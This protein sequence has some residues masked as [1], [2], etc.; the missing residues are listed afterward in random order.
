MAAV[1][2]REPGLRGMRLWRQCSQ[3]RDR[4]AMV[5]DRHSWNFK[6]AEQELAVLC[7]FK[8]QRLP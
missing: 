4:L 7:P 2:K 3:E 5:V 1:A 8:Q 6:S